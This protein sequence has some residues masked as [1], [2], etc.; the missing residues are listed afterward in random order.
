[1]CLLYVLPSLSA[2]VS[3]HQ[4]FLNLP[5]GST[6]EINLL[7]NSSLVHLYYTPDNDP[8]PRLLLDKGEF[9]SASGASYFFCIEELCIVL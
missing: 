7:L 4:N 5:Y 8:K 2:C 3:E 1:M 6:L 9:T